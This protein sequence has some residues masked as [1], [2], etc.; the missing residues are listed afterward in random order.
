MLDKCEKLDE[1]E[2]EELEALQKEMQLCSLGDRPPSPS[3][4]ML[5]RLMELEAKA[6]GVTVKEI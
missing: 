3:V 1:Y 2:Q 6:R 5:R 4:R